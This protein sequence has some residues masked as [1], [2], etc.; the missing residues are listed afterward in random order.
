MKASTA[1]RKA[2]K[3]VSKPIKFGNQYIINVW[4]K[5]HECWMESPQMDFFT[6]RSRATAARID[7]ALELLGILNESNMGIHRDESRID[8]LSYLMRANGEIR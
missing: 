6:A 5:H 7:A 1:Y 2:A 3:Q 4:S 8:P